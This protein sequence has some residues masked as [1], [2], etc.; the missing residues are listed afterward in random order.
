MGPETVSVVPD[1][2]SN[3]CVR[4]PVLTPHWDAIAILEE[5]VP[6]FPPPVPRILAPTEPL[7]MI[8]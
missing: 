1:A 2:T 3:S 4:L 6:A 8:Y 7:T 5:M